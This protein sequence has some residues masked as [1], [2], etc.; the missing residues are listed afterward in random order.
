MKIAQKA[1]SQRENVEIGAL[2]FILP[3]GTVLTY[4]GRKPDTGFRYRA[5]SWISTRFLVQ[6]SWITHTNESF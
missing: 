1:I 5:V 4:L 3:A 6:S 2:P